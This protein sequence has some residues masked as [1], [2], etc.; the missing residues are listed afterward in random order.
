MEIFK[1]KKFWVAVGGVAAVV[2][3]NVFG[4]AEDKVND[5]VA[6]LVSFILGQGLADMGKNAK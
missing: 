5:V 4:V 2:V 1:S 3:A 6:L